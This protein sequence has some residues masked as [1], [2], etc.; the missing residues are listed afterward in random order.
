MKIVIL[1]SNKIIKKGVTIDG[2]A[3]TPFQNVQHAVSPDGIDFYRV[4]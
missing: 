4:C 1:I 3:N 2:V